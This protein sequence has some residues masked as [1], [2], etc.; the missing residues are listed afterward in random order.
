MKII[1]DEEFCAMDVMGD[2]K[3]IPSALD[4]IQDVNWSPD[5]SPAPTQPLMDAMGDASWFPD[6]SPAPTESS[7]DTIQDPNWITNYDHAP[8]QPSRPITSNIVSAPITNLTVPPAWTATKW[9]DMEGKRNRLEG[10]IK[11]LKSLRKSR[12]GG[13]AY[14]QRRYSGA[15]NFVVHSITDSDTSWNRPSGFN[16][17]ECAFQALIGTLQTHKDKFIRR[18][19]CTPE[20][21]WVVYEA[22]TADDHSTMF[23]IIQFMRCFFPI[24]G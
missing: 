12:D 10:S 2:Q 22:I 18:S 20:Q 4:L 7:M 11:R 15:P 16:Y 5:Y 6:Y 19:K 1:K 9:Q 21:L 8:T 23:W 13:S 3:S 24:S 14:T 17:I